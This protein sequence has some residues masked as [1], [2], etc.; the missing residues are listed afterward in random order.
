MSDPLERS[1]IATAPLSVV[2]IAR[3]VSPILADV[4]TAWQTCLGGL[5]RD[6]EILLVDDG[7]TDNTAEVLAGLAATIPHL[8]VLRPDQPTGIGAALRTGMAAASK[9]LLCYCTADRQYQP[10]ELQC[11]L[12]AIDA[13]DLVVGYRKW[14]P[15]PLWFRIPEKIYRLFLRI[16]LGIPTEARSCWLGRQGYARRWLARWIFGIPLADP[17]CAFRLFRREVLA[18]MP[19]Q[20][21]GPF[22]HIELL[23]KVNFMGALLTQVP[24]SY[25]PPAPGAP[26]VGLE[27][28]PARAI[29]RILNHP[30]F[31]GPPGPSAGEFAQEVAV[32]PVPSTQSGPSLGTAVQQSQEPPAP[33]ENET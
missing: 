11:L 13:V 2:L 4:L 14:L 18:R 23:A 10:A 31:L 3:N 28:I 24:L 26:A 17:E 20:S 5:K 22:V 25:Y 27:K 15:V 9:P 19:I 12:D 16:I 7:S 33:C 1:P 29:W 8:Q 30:K 6:Y 21:D 32:A